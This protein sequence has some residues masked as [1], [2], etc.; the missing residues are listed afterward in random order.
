MASGT[1]PGTEPALEFDG[2]RIRRPDRSLLTYYLVASLLTL[3]AFPFVFI[4]LLIKYMT[5]EYRI[6]DQGVSMAWGYLFRRQVLLTYRRIQDIH[7]RRNIL[8]RW[9]GLAE[10]ALQT[11]SGAAGAQMT[12]EGILEPER[13]RDYLYTRMRGVKNQRP[14]G[15]HGPAAPTQETGRAASSDQDEALALLREI[16]DALKASLEPPQ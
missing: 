3:P 16:R 2:S 15:Q 11:A 6:D 14:E 9:L 1:N 8:H 10:I 7:L 13:L 4:P 12:L 5:L